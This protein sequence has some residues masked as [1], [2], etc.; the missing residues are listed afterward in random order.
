[1]KS[2]IIVSLLSVILFS[3]SKNDTKKS[4]PTKVYTGDQTLTT[5][6]DLDAFAANHYTEITGSL[7]IGQ[8]GGT[9]D[10]IS[11]E[12]LES[13]QKVKTLTISY[14]KSLTSLKGLDNLESVSYL[15]ISYNDKL[16]SLQGL[17]S[18]VTIGSAS[19]GGLTV[20]SNGSLT[21]FDGL[22]N[23]ETVQGTLNVYGCNKLTSLNGLEK[24]KSLSSSLELTSCP[25]GNLDPLSN[26]I[27][28]GG[29]L[30]LSQL[31]I[32][33]LDGLSNLTSVDRV[34]ISGNTK[35]SDF[36]GIKQ[37]L[38]GSLSAYTVQNNLYNPTQQDISSG[39]CS[40]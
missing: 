19:S 16:N 14:L 30:S 32:M 12:Q 21:S 3:C 18:L 1:M 7:T 6:N 33:N 34:L 17:G 20:Q 9:N 22:N 31:D 5:Q 10:I 28:I 4:Y 38:S 24:L 27:S 2:V 26:L 8:S 11:L 40:Q 29:A 25:L 36:C 23:L 15:R 37:A 35:L 39:S 13:I